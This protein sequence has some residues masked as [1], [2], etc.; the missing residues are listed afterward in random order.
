MVKQDYIEQSRA[1]LFAQRALGKEAEAIKLALSARSVVLGIPESFAKTRLG[2]IALV[3]AGNILTRLGNLAPNLYIDVPDDVAVL[4]GIPLLPAGKRLGKSLLT[5]MHQLAA[6]QPGKINRGWTHPSQKYDYG[7]FIGSATTDVSKAV[8]VGAERWIAALNPTGE[9]E[10]IDT[11]DKNPLGVIL[12]AALGSIEAVK[13]LWLPIKDAAVTIEPIPNR[14]TMSAYDFSINRRSPKNPAL[15]ANLTLGH[16]C[17]I[18]L[19]AIGSACNYIL[20]CLPDAH[21][22]VDFVD[23]DVIEP[24]NEERLFTSSDP[25]HDVGQPKVTHAEQFIT[26]LHKNIRVF[27]Y[28]MPFEHYV[29]ISRERLGY[30]WCFLDD[31]RG[32]RLLQTELASVLV[33][34]GTD[35]SRWM[36]S[37]HE[38]GRPENACLQDLYP[39]PSAK[40]PDPIGDLANFLGLER[41]QIL[42]IAAGHRK[43]DPSLIALAVQRQQNPAMKKRIA[44]FTGLTLE[45]A[46]VHKCSQVSPSDSLHAATISFVS[47]MPAI[48]SVADLLKRRLYGWH[49]AKGEPN[50]FQLDCFRLLENA[51]V[52]NVLAAR[53]C[54]C[55]SEHY[56]I[57]FHKRQGL[58]REYFDCIFTKPA[59]PVPLQQ[60]V[61]HYPRIEVPALAFGPSI[62]IPRPARNAAAAHQIQRFCHKHH[63]VIAILLLLLSLALYAGGMT[64]SMWLVGLF[65][66]HETRGAS[67][68]KPWQL[69][70][71][72]FTVETEGWPSVK[73]AAVSF[74]PIAVYPVL[75]CGC[76]KMIRW[77]RFLYYLRDNFKVKPNSFS[78]LAARMLTIFFAATGLP[79]VYIGT[80]AFA[81]ISARGLLQGCKQVTEQTCCFAVPCLLLGGFGLFFGCLMAFMQL[82]GPTWVRCAKIFGIAEGK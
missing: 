1:E 10:N 44:S 19:G 65:V 81:V 75:M 42:R 46:L 7:L 45:Q 53:N 16:A 21:M 71:L 9:E 58:R 5:F 18:G 66:Q 72:A 38:F 51:T 23:M 39:E 27:A 57:A 62:G 30:V 82:F 80:A 20:G 15:P 78:W 67:R 47:L 29:N 32:R 74:L 79:C 12:A 73:Y 37:L 61:L 25:N 64:G 34:A 50:I 68:F 28:K 3:T 43:F 77:A 69:S 13:L 36:V 26:S 33:N 76:T 8:T 14:T 17:V 2:Q 41:R 24:S 52:C 31:V 40:Q 54:L 59:A 55:Q 22:S 49:L 35:M 63:R 48:F 70:K 6:I 11:D 4:P 56:R 60:P